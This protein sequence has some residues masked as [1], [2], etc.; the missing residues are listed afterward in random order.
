MYF[1]QI[2]ACPKKLYDTLCFIAGT[3]SVLESS[4]LAVRQIKQFEENLLSVKK[5]IK[6]LEED[7]NSENKILDLI[8]KK[9]EILL[10]LKN[11]KKINSISEK[12]YE[13]TKT[14]LS[15]FNGV[16]IMKQIEDNYNEIIKL[17]R[18]LNNFENNFLNNNSAN[19]FNKNLDND[20]LMNINNTESNENDIRNKL[21][22]VNNNID[23]NKP[24][25]FY[26]ISNITAE[27]NVIDTENLIRKEKNIFTQL[28]K[29]LNENKNIQKKTEKKLNDQKI[30]IKDSIDECY[31]LSEVR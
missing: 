16:S 30:Q 4:E 11:A 21:N 18:T 5:I 15:L 22:Q 24:I 27:N 9:D 13:R 31:L 10:N 6:N 19:N 26:E 28:E 7:I 23:H 2:K 12:A 29:D 3:H 20:T 14:Y 17:H 8:I 25:E 1:L